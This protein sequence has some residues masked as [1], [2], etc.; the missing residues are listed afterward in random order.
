[1]SELVLGALVAVALAAVAAF[2]KVFGSLYDLR[3]ARLLLENLMGADGFDPRILRLLFDVARRRQ[4]LG[5]ILALI[6][7]GMVPVGWVIWRLVSS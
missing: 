4:R 6:L 2:V 7:I 5:L 1:M 3:K